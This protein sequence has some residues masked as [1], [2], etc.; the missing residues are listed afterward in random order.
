MTK[1]EYKKNI[2]ELMEKIDEVRNKYISSNARFNIGDKVVK[3]K[4]TEGEQVG[5]VVGYKIGS[6]NDHISTKCVKCKKDGTPSKVEMFVYSDDDL[7]K[8][9]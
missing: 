9:E 3:D 6:W 1:E 4:G 2:K 7:T 5:F 8:Y